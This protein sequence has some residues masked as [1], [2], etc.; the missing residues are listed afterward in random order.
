MGLEVGDKV[1]VAT[2]LILLAK[3]RLC[4]KIVCGLIAPWF[5]FEEWIALVHR[6]RISYSVCFHLSVYKKSV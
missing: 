3:F 1:P 5:G 2:V 4:G 6:A